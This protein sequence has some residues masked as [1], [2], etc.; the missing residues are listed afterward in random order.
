VSAQIYC[1]DYDRS[2]MFRLWK[3]SNIRLCVS[4][5]QKAELYICSLSTHTYS[6]KIPTGDILAL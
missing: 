1:S 6:Y 4:E 3:L 2:Y 5:V